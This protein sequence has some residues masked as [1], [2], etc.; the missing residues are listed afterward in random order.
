MAETSLKVQIAGK[1]YPITVED[2]DRGRIMEVA[3]AINDKVKDFE[4][5]YFVHDKRDLLAMSAL[6][7]L[8]DIN[9]TPQNSL[10]VELEKVNQLD[11][12]VSDYLQ[13]EGQ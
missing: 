2:N 11:S 1:T 4:Q 8:T 12:Y 13:K 3:K 6:N 5:N 9:N 7:L 10:D